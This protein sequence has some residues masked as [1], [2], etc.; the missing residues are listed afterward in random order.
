MFEMDSDFSQMPKIKVV[1]VGGGGSSAVNRMIE[2]GVQGVEFCV[3]NTDAQALRLSH[4]DNRMQIGKQLTGGLGAGGKPE[5]GAESAEE[6]IE[7]LKSMVSGAD[8]IFV[9]AGMGG[10]T[11]TGAAPVV[12][13]LARE[14]GALTVGI[15]TRPFLYEGKRRT[16]NAYKG[17]EELRKNVD[18][19]IIIPNDRLLQIVDT[20]TSILDAFRV[21]D[22][23]LRQGVQG[24]AEIITTPGLINLDF[25]DVRTVMK[26]GGTAL[27]GIGIADGEN[28]A[29]EAARKAI[30]SPLLETSISGASDA[31]INITGGTSLS[32]FETNAAVEEIQSAADTEINVFYGSAINVDLTDEVI[33]TVIA[34]GFDNSTENAI[35][36]AIVVQADNSIVE[37]N[38]MDNEPMIMT[39][40]TR[41][42]NQNNQGDLGFKIPPIIKGKIR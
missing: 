19:M 39:G 21:A 13:R 42:S 37:D 20:D 23:V 38:S 32:L 31:I 8:M 26:N 30:S 28:R 12:A 14:A 10:G 7:D 15:V 18:T 9:T 25:A 5:V 4:A 36:D 24:I 3:V 41:Q 27:M 35:N 11:G 40:R 6:S 29:I 1:G 33:V 16:E 17:I 22:N 2:N 34:T